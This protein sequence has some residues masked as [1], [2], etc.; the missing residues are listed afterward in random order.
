MWQG[1]GKTRYGKYTLLLSLMMCMTMG[2]TAYFQPANPE[3]VYQDKI[4]EWQLRQETE[5]W[6]SSLVRD[7]VSGCLQVAKYESEKFPMDHW[8]TYSE[9]LESNFRGDCEDITF[10]AGMTLRRLGYPHGIKG[11]IYRNPI[12]KHNGYFLDHT[13]L[14]VE[15][16]DGRWEVFN[17]VG[18]AG[19]FDRLISY[20]LTE[21]DLP[22]NNE[23][24]MIGK[25]SQ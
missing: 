13:V 3:S 25:L 24:P 6:S 15:M 7:I 16:P 4:Q 8:K 21:F 9:F 10:F 11:V 20:R 12:L 19:E 2:C 18:G 22:E 5:G 17:S 1:H 14:S 23:R